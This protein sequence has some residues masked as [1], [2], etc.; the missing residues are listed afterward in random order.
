MPRGSGEISLPAFNGTRSGQTAYRSRDWK[1]HGNAGKGV[2]GNGGRSAGQRYQGYRFQ[3]IV[4]A[5]SLCGIKVVLEYALSV[6]E[7]RCLNTKLCC[8]YIK[9]AQKIA[10]PKQL[11]W[12]RIPF[13]LISFESHV[14]TC[15]S[16]HHSQ[17]PPALQAPRS[18]FK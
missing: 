17:C 5:D 9:Q 8:S 18:G 12:K 4:Q 6:G 11:K 3:C 16:D 13:F 7:S 1:G 10:N 2:L 15:H 14:Y